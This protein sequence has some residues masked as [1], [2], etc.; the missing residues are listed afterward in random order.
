MTQKSTADSI[1][2]FSQGLLETTSAAAAV[3]NGIS[4]G[5]EKEAEKSERAE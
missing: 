5:V 2:I 1:N 3:S 4:R